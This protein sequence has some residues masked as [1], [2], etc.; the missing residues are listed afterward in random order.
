MEPETAAPW[1]CP[2]WFTEAPAVQPLDAAART[3]RAERRSSVFIGLV[4]SLIASPSCSAPRS[5][6]V[7]LIGTTRKMRRGEGE[8]TTDS[9]RCAVGLCGRDAPLVV[10][11][12]LHPLALLA[13]ACAAAARRL[14]TRVTA[15][16]VAMRAGGKGG[17]REEDQEVFGWVH[18]HTSKRGVLVAR[19]QAT[20][21]PAFRARAWRAHAAIA[22]CGRVAG[23]S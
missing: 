21:R 11:A 23:Q 19:L 4:C 3:A 17:E 16:A 20:P 14:L 6:P 12:F 18:M 1:L 8:V 7:T 13:V 10:A 9:K 15:V 2:R 5:D 22:R